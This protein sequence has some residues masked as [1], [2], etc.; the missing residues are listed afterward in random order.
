VGGVKST[1]DDQT[2]YV[3]VGGTYNLGPGIKLFGGVQFWDFEDSANI[4]NASPATE[5]E[6]TVGVIGTKFSF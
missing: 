5:G 4:A 1:R 2:E 6:A 3:S